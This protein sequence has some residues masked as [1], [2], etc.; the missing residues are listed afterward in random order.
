MPCPRSSASTAS[1]LRKHPRAAR[2]EQVETDP[3]AVAVGRG[4]PAEPRGC[5]NRPVG[6]DAAIALPAVFESEKSFA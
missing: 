5:D 1:A 2:E 4:A 3:G 6:W